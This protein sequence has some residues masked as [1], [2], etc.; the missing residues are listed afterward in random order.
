MTRDELELILVKLESVG[1]TVKRTDSGSAPLN[2]T[3]TSRYAQLPGDYAQFLN[4]VSSCANRDETAWI[5]C[6]DNFNGTDSF[7][8]KWNEWELMSAEWAIKAEDADAEREVHAFWDRHLPV[9]ISVKSAYAYLALSLSEADFGTVVT[10]IEPEF[11]VPRFF[12]AS[13]ESLLWM[14]AQGTALYETVPYL[15]VLV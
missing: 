7:E 9:L 11:E 12:C 6:C 1:W 5:L 15:R 3:I 4:V 8:F 14:L 10:G 13:F 2:Q